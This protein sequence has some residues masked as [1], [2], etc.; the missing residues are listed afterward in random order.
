MEEREVELFPICETHTD[1][2]GVAIS[3]QTDTKTSWGGRG[4]ISRICHVKK[5]GSTV[6]FLLSS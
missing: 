2:C 1:K 4:Y 6:R 3:K 5:Q